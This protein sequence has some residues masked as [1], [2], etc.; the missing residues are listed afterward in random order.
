MVGLQKR[1]HPMAKKNINIALQGG[2]AHGAFTWGVLDR[3]LEE[4]EL[5]LS[6]L[7]GTSAGAM[8]AAM[9]VEGYSRDGNAGARELLEHF[10]L[11]ISKLGMLFSP[12]QQTPFETASQGFNLDW[13]L[14]YNYFD[15]LSRMASPYEL[16]PLNIN[17]LRY[18]LENCLDIKNLQQCT[19][20]QLFIAATN[21][22]TGQPRIFRCEEITID[23]LLASACIPQLFQAVM[24][25]GEPYWDGGYMGNPAIW[26][27][28]YNTGTPDVL[29]IQI[30]PIERR[31]VPIRSHEIANRLNEITFNSSLIAEIRAINFVKKLIKEDRLPKDKYKNIHLHLIASD[32]VQD[33][34]TASSKMNAR[35]DFFCF[36]RD[37]GR[38]AA[39]EWIKKHWNDVGKK[40]T[41]D[42]EKTFLKRCKGA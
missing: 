32:Q 40:T 34:L 28:I 22:Y 17:P 16:N 5:H 21:V 11:E 24:I 2:G 7:S 3:L 12:L 18:V 27:L 6:G 13:S 42:I 9:V 8:N 10:W 20:I 36:L 26:P 25:E 38:E 1:V 31:E 39:D 23:V 29:L 4:K 15:L 35:W 33:G 41:F 19:V 14:S 30:N 37:S